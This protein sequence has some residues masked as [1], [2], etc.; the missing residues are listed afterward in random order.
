ML[1]DGTVSEMLRV[2]RDLDG[3]PLLLI[4]SHSGRSADKYALVTARIDGEDVVPTDAEVSRARVEPVAAVWGVIGHATRAVF[5][6]LEAVERAEPGARSR[7]AS[8]IAAGVQGQTQVY[9]ALRR[10]VEFGLVERGHG[11][12]RRTARTLE[13]VAD[14]H[15]VADWRADRIERF[16]TERSA[17]QRL[18]SLWNAEAS[19]DCPEVERL[20][21][22]PMPAD[23]REAWLASVIAAGPPDDPFE[24][25]DPAAVDDLAITL[26]TDVLGARI[27]DDS[28]A[29]VR[30]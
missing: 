25:V 26:L 10:L 18:L 27:I 23:E 15:Q 20:P 3:S 4:E 28:F 19:E 11:W 14:E 17:W 5:E 21:Q 6:R 7:V 12:V 29:V 30:A 13:E 16:R 2:L 9:A 22:D 24:P 8:L 1:D